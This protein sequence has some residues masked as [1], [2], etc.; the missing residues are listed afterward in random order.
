MK[1]RTRKLVLFTSLALASFSVFAAQ[2]RPAAG[3]LM[4]RWSKDVSPANVLPEY[5]RPQLVRAAW[6]NLNGPWDYAIADKDA[7]QPTKWD[8]QILVPFPVESAL[9]GVMKPVTEK[10]RLWYHRTFKLAR[11]WRG[12]N[13]LLHFGAADWEAAVWVNGRQLGVHRGG[14]DGFSFDITDVVK[15]GSENEIIVSV[16]DPSDTGAQAHGKQMLHPRGIFYTATT[17]IWQ[18]PWLEPVANGHVEDLKTVPD[19][20]NASVSV[21]AL[22]GTAPAMQMELKIEVLAGLCVVQTAKIQR[23]TGGANYVLQDWHAD[24]KLPEMKTWSPAS[25]FLY[26]LRITVFADGKKVDEVKSYFGMRKISLGKDAKGI[27]RL[28][29]NN[30]PL[31]EFGPLDQGF[32][33]DGIYTAPTDEALRRDIEMTKKLGFNMCRKHVKVEP[34]RWYYWADKLGL[35]VWQDM[36]SSGIGDTKTDKIRSGHE[37]D[38]KQFEAELSAMIRGRR[39]HPSIVMWVPF[40]EGWGQYET[41]RI[42][43]LVKQLD[44]TRLINNASGWTDRQV[45][46]VADLHKYPAPGMPALEEKRAAVLGEFGGLG[47]PVKGHTWQTEKNWG[48]KSFKDSAELTGAYLDLLAQMPS[49]V[50]AGLSAAVYTQTTDCETEVNG[51]MTYDRALVKMPVEK[52]APANKSIADFFQRPP[53]SCSQWPRGASRLDSAPTGQ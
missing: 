11:G 30:Q 52:I 46:D 36:P 19:L 17:G 8:G 20:D 1:K 51:L 6:L 33:P 16:W 4:T 49:L 40:N 21:N 37:N 27:T 23:D 13:I 48:Y 12:K 22:V 7:P 45:G 39:N 34:D 38:A 10:Q 28:C 18:T 42:V 50:E 24:L 43:D 2:W 5:P 25:P 31:F 53:R 29:L 9:S 32:W 26:D 3:P 44:P 35:L 15:A 14:Y 47:L 41:P